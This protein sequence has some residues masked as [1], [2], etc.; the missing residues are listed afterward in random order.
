MTNTTDNKKNEIKDKSKKAREFSASSEAD[1]KL[2]GASKAQ[3]VVALRNKFFNMLYRYST[4]VF[5][6]S[7]ATFVF[8]I[9]FAMFFV[10]QPVPP[11]YIPVNEDGTYIKLLSL[12]K[13]KTDAEVQ[14]FAVSGI[15]KLYKYDY[16]N[17]AEQLQEA[18][19]YF[20]RAGWNEYL[21]EYSRSD[22]L[23]AVKEN[24]WI[25]SVN[26]NGLPEILNVNVVN[27]VCTYELKAPVSILY[28]GN[29]TSQNPNGNLFLKVVRT[30][31]INNPEG[32]GIAKV[33]LTIVKK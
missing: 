1:G 2:K 11:Q 10:K 5:F 14:K 22:I 17:Y 30:S 29:N 16:I 25:V 13:C 4:L 27:G 15:K 12:D 20:T 24:K 26:I 19:S 23:L 31:V 6:S 3:T 21:E 7:L 9:F 28:I 33:I 18:A 32:L 8:S